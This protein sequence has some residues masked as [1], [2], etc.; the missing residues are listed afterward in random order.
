MPASEARTDF[1]AATSA[2]LPATLPALLTMVDFCLPVSFLALADALVLRFLPFVEVAFFLV[3]IV[4][5]DY[6]EVIRRLRYTAHQVVRLAKTSTPALIPVAATSVN[7][8][9]W[10]RL[11]H[12]R[13]YWAYL[14]GLVAIRPL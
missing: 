8:N 9:E 1:L 13:A 12:P 10:S 6:L 7:T 4:K 2:A 5:Y 3:A 14:V 11:V